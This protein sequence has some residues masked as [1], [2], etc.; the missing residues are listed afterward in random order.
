MIANIAWIIEWNVRCLT[1]SAFIL[2]RWGVRP[3]PS[4][5][6]SIRTSMPSLAFRQ[7]MSAILRPY[8]PPSRRLASIWMVLSAPDIA[9]SR[10]SMPS[11][12]FQ[13]NETSFPTV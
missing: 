13:W 6:V 12:A 5:D 4:A 9:F 10:L 1:P 11:Y 2:R 7:R 3:N 8:S